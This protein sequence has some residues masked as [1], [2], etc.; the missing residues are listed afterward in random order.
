MANY[1]I[2]DTSIYRELGLKFNE[3][4]DY[5]NLCAFTLHTDGEV[6]LSNIVIEEF[7]NYY[8]SILESKVN[9]YLKSKKDLIRDP[10]FESAEIT[11]KDITSDIKKAKDFFR[12]T[13]Q[14]DPIHEHRISILRPTMIS[15]LEL[16]K[17]ILQSKET[18]DSN[19]Q[20]R[21]Y[22]IWD[23]V[24]NFAK[25]ESED[26]IEKVS[27][28]KI[29]FEKSIITFISKDKGF[30]ENELFK[31]LLTNYKVDNVEVLKSIP[32]FLEKKGFY[33]DFI[34]ESLIQEKIT[35]KR[36]LN[37]LSKDIGALLSYVSERY[38]ENC[39]EKTIEES[40]IEKIEVLEHYTYIDS[41]DNKHKF[42]A[43]LK[44]WVRVV[45]EKDEVG[46]KES[47][48]IENKRWRSLE[49][50]DQLKRPYFQK[51]ILF[52]YGGLVNVERKSIKSV[53]FLD[54]MPDMYLND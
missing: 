4:I 26:R 23:S 20:I 7:S 17:F 49:T 34:T 11:E 29:T 52:F 10:Y 39:Y 2:L 22:L 9:S 33:F 42:T 8:E 3:H 31:T 48:L 6:L 12:K 24:L 27:R 21:D 53:R 25:E 36:I 41:K 13:L 28:R 40:E 47:L 16:T 44:V 43:N 14:N 19:V 54:Y 37:D 38:H 45:F 1:V 5:K 35:P 18:K 32:E 51:P 50:Y 30:E 46:Y 15:G